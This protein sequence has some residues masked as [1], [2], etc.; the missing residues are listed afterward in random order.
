MPV[1]GGVFSVKLDFD[2]AYFDGSDRWLEIAVKRPDEMK[3]TTL[4]VRQKITSAPYS[5]KSKSADEANNAAQLGGVNAD[6]YVTTSTV[7]NSFIKND[8]TQQTADFNVSGN[9]ILGGAL[10]A[11]EVIAQTPS[12]TYGLTQTDGTT[13]VSTY[14]GNSSSGANGGWFG[15]RSNSPLFLFTNSGQPTMTLTGGNVGIGTVTPQSRIDRADFD[16]QSV[17]FH[18]HERHDN[19]RDIR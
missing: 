10:Q 13:T 18:A 7:G 9:G 17:W 14:V 16:F 19:G 12:G 1:A 11:T 15:T 2:A 6:E 3:F 4:D 5:V 8:V